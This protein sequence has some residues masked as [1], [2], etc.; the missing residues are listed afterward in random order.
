MGAGKQFSKPV[1]MGLL[2]GGLSLPLHA[3]LYEDGLIAYASG[4]HALASSYFSE[5]AQG[6]HAGAEHMLA[7]LFSEGIGV[8]RDAAAALKWTQKAAK[9][10]IALAQYNLAEMI[11][12]GLNGEVAAAD[13]AAMYQWYAKSAQGGV[14]MSYYRMAQLTEQGRGV[15]KNPAEA[16]N[17]YSVA[18]AELDVFAQKGDPRSQNTLA[19]MYETGKGVAQNYA[20]A[21]QWYRQAA[22]QGF[23]EA[24]FNVGRMFAAGN[25]VDKNAIEAMSWF[26][27][28]AQQGY[29][30]AKNIVDA[31]VQ[32]NG[33]GSVAMNNER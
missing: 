29:A 4:E 8:P 27:R 28:A 31:K 16:K 18:A 20:K 7:R 9:S 6:G 24:Q 17:L 1:M 2:L 22:N 25:G 21:V 15:A 19:S 5:A 11:L 12:N 3:D 26:R 10:G 33:H 14:V 13:D 32:G 30:K 23:A